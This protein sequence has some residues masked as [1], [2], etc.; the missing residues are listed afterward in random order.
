[1]RDAYN[2]DWKLSQLDGDLYDKISNNK[3]KCSHFS[4]WNKMFTDIPALRKHILT[5][6]ERHFICPIEG[7]GK[8]FLDNSKLKRHQLVHT[9][10]KPFRWD[11]C[12][13]K[14]SLDFN[15]RTHYRTHTGEKPYICRFDGWNKRF[16][17]SSNLTAHEKTHNE[18]LGASDYTSFSADITED[19]HTY[20]DQLNGHLNEIKF[21]HCHSNHWERNCKHEQILE[22]KSL[23]L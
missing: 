3:Y 14:F 2:D 11:I 18:L 19:Q 5:H 1:M 9:G 21:R 20:A 12:N 8:K 15:L 17:Q 7:W 10:E 22:S 6:G 13:K 16:T 23:N 4:G